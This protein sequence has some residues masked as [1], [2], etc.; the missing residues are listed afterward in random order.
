MGLKRVQI[1]LRNEGYHTP[2]LKVMKKRKRNDSNF[3]RNEILMRKN[4]MKDYLWTSWCMPLLYLHDS[5]FDRLVL[6]G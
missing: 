3:E 5:R 6:N 2:K 1:I 4:E